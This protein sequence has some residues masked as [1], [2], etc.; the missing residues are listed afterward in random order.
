MTAPA[1]HPGDTSMTLLVRL[2]RDDQAAWARLVYLYGPLV[3]YWAARRGVTGADADDVTQD[4]FR[5]VAGGLAGF[6][7]DRPGDSFRGWLH[8]VTRNVLLRHATA[9]GRRPQAVGGSEAFLELHAV[10][11]T[12]AE[13]AGTTTEVDALYRRGLE[14]VRGE[15]EPRTWRA[16]WE[17]VVDGRTPADVAADLG[18]SAATVRQA[19]SRV[20]RRLREELGD[21]IE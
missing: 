20:L 11:E 15:F 8:G 9:A 4:V 18:V 6:R 7:R 21:L 12:P 10:A 19:K 14:L 16:F 13:D 2:R 5:A 17:Y 1:G 3:R